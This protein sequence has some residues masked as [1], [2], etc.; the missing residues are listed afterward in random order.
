MLTTHKKSARRLSL[1]AVVIAFLTF[2][3]L[4]VA[5]SDI[6]YMGTDTDGN[7]SWISCGSSAGAYSYSCD[8][9]GNCH[10]TT[11]WRAAAF[12]DLPQGEESQR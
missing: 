9:Q 1:I 8:A 11:D 4:A 6:Y 12:C 10:D 7:T 3:T 2:I 5:A